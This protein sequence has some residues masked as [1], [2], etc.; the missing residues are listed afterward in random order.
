MKKMIYAV[1]AG[2]K[3][4]IFD[5][6]RK[7]SEQTNKY[8]NAK[9]RRFEYQSE[10][11]DAP[12]HVPGSLRNAINEAIGY[13]DG[14]PHLGG[15]DDY[16]QDLNWNRYGFLPFGHESET[17][18]SKAYAESEEEQEAD[19]SE[20]AEEEF[21]Q[22]L[23]SS[24]NTAV[25]PLGYWKTAQIMADCVNNIKF[26]ETKDER[27]EAGLLLRKKLKKC[28]SDVNLYKLTEIYRD[29][30]ARNILGYDPPAVATFVSRMK[31][32]YPKPEP[33]EIEVEE[34]VPVRQIF[35]QAGAIETELGEVVLGQ[36]AAIE[37]LSESYF[38]TEWKRCLTLNKR[39]PR[40]AY[41]LAGPP[42]VGKTLMAQQFAFRL[43]I[44]FKRFDMSGYSNRES[45]QELV[46]FAPTWRDSEPGLLTE[47]VSEKPECV[48]LFDEIEKAEISVIRLFLQILDDGICEDKH[49]Q[50]DVS[51]KK[52]IIF[53][54]TNAAKQLYSE[55]QNENLTLLPD[56]VI[57]DALMKDKDAHTG[58]PLFPPEILSR[59]SSHTIIMLN[60]LKAG[61]ILDLVENN[62]E[63]RFRRLKKK[64]G[65]VMS[66]GKENLARTAL[67]SLGGSADARNASKIA[68]KLI[69]R[70]LRKFLDML[71]ERQMLEEDDKGRK[72]EWKCDFENATQEIQDFYFGERNCVIPVFGTVK[73][74]PAGKLEHNKVSVKNT[75]DINEF[76]DMIHKENVLFAVVDYIYGIENT[77]N[78]MNVADAR[79]V[80]GEVLLKLREE[81]KEIP[82]YI[83][84]G[85]YEYL[86]TPK[87]KNALIKK[88]VEG[89]IEKRSLGR[90]LEKAY[91]DVCCRTVMETLAA[92]HQVLA[93]ETR[94]EFDEKTNM[95]SVVFYG[96]K[97]ETA[98]ESED[99][100][101]MLSDDL[102]PNKSWNDICVS[103]YLREE[104]GLVI[105]YLKAPKEYQRRGL[106]PKGVLLYG[107]PGT[108]KTL[109]AKVVAAESKVNFLSIS[110]SELFNGGAA[111]VH[112]EFRIARKYAPAILFIDEID[113]VSMKREYS[114]A[115]NPT[116]N[117]LLTEMDGFKKVDNKPVFV[118]AATN[119]GN[120][121]D[122]AL[123]RRFDL[124]FVMD[125]LDKDGNRKLLEKLIKKQ[126]DMFEISEKKI[127]S[128]AERAVGVSPA[129]LE[130][131]IEAALREGIRSDCKIDDDL[132]DEMFERRI[133]GV[134]R[135]DRSPKEIARTAYHEAGH[136][137]L[138]LYYGRPPAYMSIVARGSQAGYVRS[139]T[140]EKDST[141]KYCLEEICLALGGRAAETVFAD[142]LKLEGGPTYSAVS[143]LE[144]ATKIAAN[145][146]CKWG[147]YEEEMGLAVSGGIE[148][149]NGVLELTCDEKAKALI[150]RILSE[151]LKEAKRII[152]LNKDAMVRLVEAVMDQGDKKKYLI[153]EE[154]IQAA[155]ELKKE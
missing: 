40:S 121:I 16:L 137:L 42:G 72:I 89:F 3:T 47:F 50:C 19:E 93:Y 125:H 138:A 37:K 98:V 83:L 75:T 74:E 124:R 114:S 30:P 66:R 103:D 99:K 22:W 73:Y 44:P 132:L 155:G 105:K 126:S 52:A 88:G 146:V 12:E 149:K 148:E 127:E 117:A 18:D 120:R 43:G 28:L 21:D 134:E 147:M 15:S 82:V 87:E 6:W 129:I 145:M 49:N 31:A 104:L 26:A 23:A 84:N 136:A 92:R 154:I 32:A 55:A 71:E 25:L 131:I 135:F 152:A 51:F 4:G 53:F 91:L 24:R 142:A 141:R 27:R 64:Y 36:E 123:L 81:Y 79:S 102:R 41:L 139:G 80:G 54:T 35:M 94:Q 69:D 8:S 46:G 97:L 20:A 57:V 128:I 140:E 65:Y 61:A 78:V 17:D 100:S 45:I 101:S 116:L 95:G 14:L 113:A 112:D 151:Q 106:R 39:G 108:G 7:C 110:A 150:N 67:Y 5:E 9:F 115:P 56:K 109:L 111:K 29:K 59:M 119:L 13:L 85:S 86:Y 153:K 122:D 58:L 38:N 70:E 63:T 77:G 118:M 68:E 62:I 144:K 143:D 107:P 133:Q 10:F 34:E 33:S 96:F 1:K 90:E 130:Q 60:H 48:L 2:R 76:M 11:E